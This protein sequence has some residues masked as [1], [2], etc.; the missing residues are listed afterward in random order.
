M[1]DKYDGWGTTASPYQKELLII[2]ME[3]CNE[4]AQRASKILRFGIDEVQPGH[5]F[6]NV[7]RLSNEIGDII[8]VLGRMETADLLDM[9]TIK[10]SIGLKEVKLRNFMREAPPE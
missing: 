9:K 6:N 10:A 1:T 2:F 5:M 8:A 4:A 3:E 7:A